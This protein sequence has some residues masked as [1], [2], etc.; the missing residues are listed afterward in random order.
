MLGF[1]SVVLTLS[2]PIRYSTSVSPQAVIAL[3]H[4]RHTIAT[5]RALAPLLDATLALCRALPG[6]RGP[7]L[8]PATATELKDAADFFNWEAGDTLGSKQLAADDQWVGWSAIDSAELDSRLDHVHRLDAARREG[9]SERA[10]HKGLRCCQRRA[11]QL[12]VEEVGQCERHR[13]GTRGL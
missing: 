9:A 6:E 1:L 2:P 5:D 7:D 10:D 3:E 13:G 12:E 11:I 8:L 4:L